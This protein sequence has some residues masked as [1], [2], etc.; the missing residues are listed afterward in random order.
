MKTIIVVYSDKLKLT[1]GE[2]GK[3][4]KY[5]FNTDNDV[6]VGDVLDSQ[7]YGTRLVVV[8]VLSK[9]HKYYNASTGDLNNTYKSTAQWEIKKLVIRQDEE[10]VVYAQ[11][12]E[13]K[14]S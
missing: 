1:K 13:T 5:A 2:I 3:M 10:E 6:E 12:V 9:A 14:T 8:K 7:A 4:K 11:K